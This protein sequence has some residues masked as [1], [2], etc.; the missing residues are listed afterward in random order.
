MACLTQN[1]K[2]RLIVFSRLQNQPETMSGTKPGGHRGHLY[3]RMGVHQVR[4]YTRRRM[5]GHF[6]VR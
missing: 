2:C 5:C 3:V 4:G 6:H 1:Y